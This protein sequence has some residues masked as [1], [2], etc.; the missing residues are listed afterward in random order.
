MSPTATP[1]GGL[2][3]GRP[4]VW[5]RMTTYALTGHSRVPPPVRGLPGAGH[6]LPSCPAEGWRGVRAPIQR[7]NS[8]RECTP[9]SAESVSACRRAVWTERPRSVA[10]RG[11][12][13]PVDS[14][15]ATARFPFGQLVRVEHTAD[16]VRRIVAQHDRA[17]D[18]PVPIGER[19]SADAERPAAPEADAHV[20]DALGRDRRQAAAARSQSDGGDAIL[21]Q[22]R[23]QGRHGSAKTADGRQRERRQPEHVVTTP[24]RESISCSPIPGIRQSDRRHD[25]VRDRI[26]IAVGSHGRKHSRADPAICSCSTG[27][28][29]LGLVRRCAVAPRRNLDAALYVIR[30]ALGSEG[31]VN[32]SPA[33]LPRSYNRPP[34]RRLTGEL[35]E[36][37]PRST[38]GCGRP[39][40]TD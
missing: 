23:A 18:V 37:A 40:R 27:R 5:R 20:E 3:G 2:A 36:R 38:R 16:R 1:A 29:W 11:M 22:H 33:G 26:S 15:N 28:L 25:T 21:R 35:G 19:R 32:G 34:P 9:R 6:H 7:A 39:I 17:L 31:G 14:R 13:R 8:A 30:R 4:P 12:P 24:A 10:I